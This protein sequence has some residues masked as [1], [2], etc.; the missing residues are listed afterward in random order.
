MDEYTT[1]QVV[2]F[3]LI[4][5]LWVGYFVLEGFDFGVGML[6][7]VI[8]RTNP[9]R[10]AVI[11]SIGPVW[12]GNE[13]WLIV[14]GGATFAAF[15]QWYATLFSG[16]YIPLFV[17]LLALIV[18]GVAFEFW[19]KDDRP[20][21]RNGWEWCITGGSA[22]AALLWGVAWANI[23][24]G[25]PIDR[26]Q[27]YVGNLL[28]LLHPYALLGGVVTLALFLSHGAI[29]LTL[30][31]TGELEA[32]A[33]A[34]ASRAAPAAAVVTIGLLVWTVVNEADRTHVEWL[35]VVLAAI[36]A[37]F[38]AGAP[39]LVAAGRAG[40][41]FAVSALAIVS[42]FAALFVDLFPHTMVSSISPQFDMTLNASSSSHY[43]LTVMTV[44][45]A[46]L[47]P[48]VLLYQGWS[49][50]VFRQRVSAEDFTPARN[51]I[52]AARGGPAADQ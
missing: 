13:V 48:I 31:T 51:P 14:A 39:A 7:R 18:R 52:D 3:V 28:D 11:H 37:V 27:E 49:Y 40:W 24:H 9:E 19:G 32:R 46:I 34:V 30:R 45:A 35:V 47:V 38:L 44:L 12:D 41:A 33:R 8:G 4:A 2:W 29:F 16:F 25:V 20:A 15:P 43:T 42:L 22:V 6:L 10:R 26:R 1:L 36:T 17:I 21:W 23:V 5:I 50:W